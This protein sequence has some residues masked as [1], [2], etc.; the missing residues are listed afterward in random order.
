MKQIISLKSVALVA[1]LSL[2]ASC[3]K[4]NEKSS[5]AEKY[6]SWIESLND[7]VAQL[8][9]S[10]Q[11]AEDSLTMMYSA[12]DSMSKSFS[13]VNNP[14]EVEGYSILSSYR[15][16]YPLVRSGVAARY[17]KGE[18]FELVAALVGGTFTKLNVA[19]AAGTVATS[20]VPFDQALNY[21]TGGI[22]T[23]LFSDSLAY[24]VGRLVNKAR[25]N[26]DAVK[27]TYLGGSNK[28]I[29]LSPTDVDV[30]ARTWRLAATRKYIR[31]L[32]HRLPIMS[33]KIDLCR[34][35][36]EEASESQDS[37]NK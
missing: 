15:G 16:N 17:S 34:R 20:S 3:A 7:S 22:N 32:E 31:D 25:E 33:K 19:T 10:R 1:M 2:L 5:Y 6:D 23:V 27:V 28:T 12:V 36:M 13:F 8:S 4:R 24:E 30:I 18:N 29:A 26:G 35:K 11:L 37:K 21:R 9:Q 14:K